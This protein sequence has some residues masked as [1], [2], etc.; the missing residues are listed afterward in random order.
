LVAHRHRFRPPSIARNFF[1]PARK[2]MLQNTTSKGNNY[3]HRIESYLQD[4]TDSSR[5][6][7]PS[8]FA[9]SRPAGRI[10]RLTRVFWNANTQE[11]HERPFTRRLLTNAQILLVSIAIEFM[12]P[13]AE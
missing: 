6:F 1:L 12:A 2:E 11:M 10:F 9:P 4:R 3:G 8:V 7:Q 5:S 13:S